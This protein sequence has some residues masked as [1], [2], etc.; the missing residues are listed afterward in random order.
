MNRHLRCT[1]QGWKLNVLWRDGT[2]S[3]EHLCNLKESN[4]V[5]VAEYAVANKLV[6]EA[7]FA[8]WVPHVLKQRE[9]IIG[10]MNSRYHKR[11]HKFGIEIPKTV[12]CALEIMKLVQIFGKKPL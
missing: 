4:P 1:T 7:A 2:T 10:A 12:K 3:W 9:R 11:T 8:W 6:E 5:Q